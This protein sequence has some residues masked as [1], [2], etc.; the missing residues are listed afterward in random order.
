MTKDKPDLLNRTEDVDIVERF[1]KSQVNGQDGCVLNVDAGWG[2]GKTFF[3]NMLNDRLGDHAVYVNAWETDHADDALLPVLA[4]VTQGLAA[5]NPDRPSGRLKKVGKSVALS[6]AMGGIRG[7]AG[8]LTAGASEG[9]LRMGSAAAE[10]L[11]SDQADALFSRFE[12]AEK[13]IKAFKDE[14]KEAVKDLEEKPFTILIDELDRCR[15][16]YAIEMLERIKHLFDIP[17][18]AFVV[19]TDTEQLQHAIKAVYGEGFDAKA[20]LRRFFGRTYRFDTPSIAQFVA[21]GLRTRNITDASFAEELVIPP[22]ALITQYFESTQ[23]EMSLR[24]MGQILDTLETCTHFWQS[25]KLLNLIVL[26]PLIAINQAGL[27][28]VFDRLEQR[29]EIGGRSDDMITSA[30]DLSSSIRDIVIPDG[31]SSVGWGVLFKEICQQAYGHGPSSTD[32]RN[33]TVS[34]ASQ[35]VSNATEEQSSGITHCTFRDYPKLVRRVGSNAGPQASP[36][37]ST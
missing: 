14:V 37:P 19:A 8:I 4:A 30:A 2:L 28:E 33:P 9:L 7:G 22:S 27:W 17:N 5:L 1:L 32:M 18:V 24:D 36:E 6:L 26:L 12:D 25:E 15:P 35:L 20:Y 34:N 11:M 29:G 21:E 13:S 3:M 23:S 10:R 31:S 16:T